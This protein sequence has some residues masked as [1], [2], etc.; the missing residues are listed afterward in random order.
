MASSATPSRIPP[1][2][3]AVLALTGAAL[4]L[5][6]AA[7]WAYGR[8]VRGELTLDLQLGRTTRP[9]GPMTVVI[10]APREVVFEVVAAPYL[11]RVPSDL[12]GS[13]E[14]VERSNDMVLAAH[15]TPVRS[16]EAVTLETVR[17][18]PPERIAF[19]LVRGP[20]PH[21]VESFELTET[22]A[23][24]ELRYEGEIG[25]DLWRAGRWWADRVAVAWEGAVETSLRHVV[26]A[27]EQRAAAQR[28]RA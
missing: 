17:F 18:E 23:G 21:V 12:S 13:I 8:L 3:G 1:A 26:E 10:D 14:V 25:A 4:A 24:T 16:F 2:T 15:R 7:T 6:G 19:R 27:S 20:V 11:G 5:A 28:R 9:L 22:P